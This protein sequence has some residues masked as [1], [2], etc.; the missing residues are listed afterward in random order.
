MIDLSQ[1]TGMRL[2]RR[3]ISLNNSGKTFWEIHYYPNTW[4]HTHRYCPGTRQTKKKNRKSTKKPIWRIKYW[5]LFTYIIFKD[6][7]VAFYPH[8]MLTASGFGN[9]V[10]NVSTHY[11]RGILFSSNQHMRLR[12]FLSLIGNAFRSYNNFNKLTSNI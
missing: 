2:S 5:L 12:N 10:T 7:E 6:K 1:S 11:T 4:V 3:K 9:C 8:S